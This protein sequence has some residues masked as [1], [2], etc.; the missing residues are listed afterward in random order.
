MRNF[1]YSAVVVLITFSLSGCS[2]SFSSPV[3]VTDRPLAEQIEERNAEAALMSDTTV[4]DAIAFSDTWASGT[5]LRLDIK[6]DADVILRSGP[7]GTYDEIASIADGAEVLATGNQT[8]EW[9]HVLYAAFDGW[10]S[11]DDVTLGA[12]GSTPALVD[13]STARQ[14]VVV[15]EVAGATIG[16]NIRTE[17][18]VNGELVSGAPVGSV[19]TG[20]G[21]SDGSW[22]E[23][24]FGET[25]GWASG[26]YLR[27]I[28]SASLTA[29]EREQLGLEDMIDG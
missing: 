3:S 11:T 28:D 20:T 27:P 2:L 25:T 22:V 23:V 8:G 13:P 26:N 5:F 17:P 18:N 12:V 15:Y 4:P 24:T 6:A 29:T 7:G 1:Q 19:V 9:I 14:Q 10:I 21:R 16:V